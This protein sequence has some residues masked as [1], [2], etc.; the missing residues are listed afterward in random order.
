MI[1]L[2]YP[3][4]FLGSRLFAGP[5]A[6]G[7]EVLAVRHPFSSETAGIH[8]IS[9]RPALSLFDLDPANPCRRVSGTPLFAIPEA[10]LLL[11]PSRARHASGSR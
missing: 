8:T 6:A 9:A 4:G 7:H 11:P 5:L 1:H 2:T 10:F 3:T